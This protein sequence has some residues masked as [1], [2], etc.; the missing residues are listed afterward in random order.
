MEY[1]IIEILLTFFLAFL[2]WLLRQQIKRIDQLEKD[3][4]SIRFNYLDRFTEIRDCP[5]SFTQVIIGVPSIVVSFSIGRIKA[6]SLA[7]IA[8]R[9]PFVA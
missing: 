9:L 8:D 7:V 6:D 3:S 5:F 4:N 2:T 1:K